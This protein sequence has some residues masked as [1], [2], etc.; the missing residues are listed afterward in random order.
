MGDQYQ[1]HTS[2]GLQNLTFSYFQKALFNPSLRFIFLYYKLILLLQ[3]IL[4]F[5]KT[6]SKNVFYDKNEINLSNYHGMRSISD[7]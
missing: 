4:L 1:V 5:Q 7:R 3:L 2:P 6:I